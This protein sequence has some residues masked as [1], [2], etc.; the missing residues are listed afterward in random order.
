MFIRGIKILTGLSVRMMHSA[1][2][3][4][5]FVSSLFTRI[6]LWS[7]NFRAFARCLLSTRRMVSALFKVM[8]EHWVVSNTST[9]GCLCDHAFVKYC[10]RSVSSVLSVIRTRTVSMSKNDVIGLSQQN[11]FTEYA[12]VRDIKYALQRIIPSYVNF[13]QPCTTSSLS[14]RNCARARTPTVEGRPLDGV[15][16]ATRR[17][18]CYRLFVRYLVGYL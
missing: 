11:Y 16:C 6:S 5:F 4:I 8:R 10:S 17:D 3:S 7:M 9:T 15:P 2:L 18:L 1:V 14:W 12:M 13:C